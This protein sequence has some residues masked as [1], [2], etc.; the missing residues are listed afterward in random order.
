MSND[1]LFI[2]SYFLLVVKLC[3]GS[4]E[5]CLTHGSHYCFLPNK[6]TYATVCNVH[7]RDTSKHTS[8]VYSYYLFL[9]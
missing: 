5:I 8:P 6:P 7:L 9:E 2:N 4:E 1:H 3:D